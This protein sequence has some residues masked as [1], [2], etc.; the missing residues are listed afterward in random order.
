MKNTD[1]FTLI[2]PNASLLQWGVKKQHMGIQY[3]PWS[4]RSM[5]GNN[6][7]RGSF[8]HD[9]SLKFVKIKQKRQFR[10]WF[11]SY[12]NRHKIFGVFKKSTYGLSPYQR[13]E[14]TGEKNNILPINLFLFICKKYRIPVERHNFIVYGH[15]AWKKP[16]T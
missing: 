12:D 14:P 13:S 2:T 9:T 7:Q 1:F 5:K 3:W 4:L 15:H 8:F 6:T 16:R 11:R 10:R